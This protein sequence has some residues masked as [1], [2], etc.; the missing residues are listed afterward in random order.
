MAVIIVQIMVTVCSAVVL[1][2]AYTPVSVIRI[3][4]VQGYL[5]IG[6]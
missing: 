1:N 4:P 3:N 2:C 6:D 5:R